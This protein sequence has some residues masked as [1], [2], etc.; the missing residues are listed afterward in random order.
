METKGILITY[1]LQGENYL[2]AGLAFCLI[3]M[4]TGR[5]ETNINDRDG[6]SIGMLDVATAII[7][8]LFLPRR[9]C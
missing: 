2:R 8:D 4:Y 3:G 6:L 7:K 1:S 9:H 5:K